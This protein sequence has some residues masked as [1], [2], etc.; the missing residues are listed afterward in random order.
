[1]AELKE[2]LNLEYI[3]LRPLGCSKAQGKEK[4]RGVAGISGKIWSQQRWRRHRF[5]EA[6]AGSIGN[7]LCYSTYGV[8]PILLADPLMP[9]NQLPFLTDSW[10]EIKDIMFK[11]D[12]VSVL[13]Y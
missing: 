6:C 5:W 2:L 7:V 11:G 13:L 12:P 9:V 1:M 8:L 4:L 3:C 10:H